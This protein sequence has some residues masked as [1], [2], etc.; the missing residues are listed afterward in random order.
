MAARGCLPCRLVTNV[1][2]GVFRWGDIDVGILL[3]RNL[4]AHLPHDGVMWA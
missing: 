2:R 3:P 4:A 1:R